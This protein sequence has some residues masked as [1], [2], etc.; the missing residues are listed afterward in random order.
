[1]DNEPPE[2]DEIEQ[3]PKNVAPSAMAFE[4]ALAVIALVLGGFFGHSPLDTISGV[5]ENYAANAKACVW[6]VL[7]TLPLLV[8]FFAL[9]YLPLD[10]FRDLVRLVEEKIA[11]LFSESTIAQLA[12]L[13]IA[14]GVGEELLFRGL[15]QDGLA[16]SI[17]GQN[18]LVVGLI[19]ASLIFGACHS[20]TQ[21]YFLLATGIGVYL[22]LLF[23]LTD[24]L[25]APIV[26][27]A[28]YD[29]VAISYL[30]RKGPDRASGA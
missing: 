1:M 14:A 5:A 18:G 21:S 16:S 25:L 19:V 10:M 17:G 6:G 27:H 28:L 26:T 13:S 9:E 23:W 7:A 15:I 8:V 29:F 11:P 4:S 12:M 2:D 20:L 30:V 3:V 22:G 24:N